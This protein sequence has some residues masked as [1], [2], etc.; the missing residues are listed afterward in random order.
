MVEPPTILTSM[1][2]WFTLVGKSEE[3]SSFVICGQS[4]MHE[5]DV[6]EFKIIVV[7]GNDDDD[8][9]TQRPSSQIVVKTIRQ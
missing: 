2:F 9:M 7:T 6:F 5:E 4:L 3:G 1:T 8:Q